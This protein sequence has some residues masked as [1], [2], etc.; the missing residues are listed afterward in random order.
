MSGDV[1]VLEAIKVL[2]NKAMRLAQYLQD[3]QPLPAAMS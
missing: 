1:L 2:R 3:T